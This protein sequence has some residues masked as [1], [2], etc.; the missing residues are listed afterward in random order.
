MVAVTAKV[1]GN[2]API[3]GQVEHLLGLMYTREGMPGHCLS[4]YEIHSLTPPTH[5][6]CMKYRRGNILEDT[7]TK[8]DNSQ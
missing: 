5:I 3:Y 1:G 7:H 2:C 8:S 6:A 4:S